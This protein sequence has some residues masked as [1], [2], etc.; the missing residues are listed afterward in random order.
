MRRFFLHLTIALLTFSAGIILSAMREA[1]APKLTDD[2][3]K[4]C[5][6]QPA[7][8]VDQDLVRRLLDIDKEY[9]VRCL[10]SAKDEADYKE[11][12]ESG[13]ITRCYGEWEEARRVAVEGE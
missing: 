5:L 7:M 12:R 3:I 6:T 13:W 1:P 2:E 10:R 4:V 9:E 11:K 8:C